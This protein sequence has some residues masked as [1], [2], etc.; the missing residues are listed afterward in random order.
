MFRGAPG[1]EA[2]THPVPTAV[3]GGASRPADPA[4]HRPGRHG[5]LCGAHDHRTGAAGELLY[6]GGEGGAGG[7]GM[8]EGER[9][10]KGELMWAS[11]GAHLSPRLAGGIQTPGGAALPLVLPHPQPQAWARPSASL[12]CLFPPLSEPAPPCR[13]LSHH[14]TSSPASSLAPGAALQSLPLQPQFFL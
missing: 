1:G 10:G 3:C 2:L 5:W 6:S 12:G 7:D 13:V 4:P 11:Q 8:G 9:R 14:H